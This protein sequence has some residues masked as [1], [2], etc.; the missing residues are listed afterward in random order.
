MK[1]MYKKITLIV[2]LWLWLWLWITTSF[3]AGT[4][5]SSLSNNLAFAPGLQATTQGYDLLSGKV[6]Q[7][8]PLVKGNI[9]F[10]M[11]YHASLRLEGEGG[12]NL[13]QELD[14]GGI[15]DWTNEYSGYVI[16]STAPSTNV[17]TFIIQLPRSSEKYI[18]T[19]D[20]GKFK[21]LYYNG[22][23]QFEAKTFYSDNLKDISFNQVN[24]AIVIVKDGVKFTASISKILES[25]FGASAIQAY[26]FKFTE[27]QYQD[28]RKLNLVYDN[29]YNLI[30]VKDNRNNILNILREYKKAG[31]TNQSYLERKLITGVELISG[32]NTQRSTITYQEAQVKSIIN[33]SKIETR[34]TVSAI[35]SV[36]V[37]TVIFQYE[38]QSRG[39]W[40][41]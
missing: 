30:Q 9:P 3:A 39:Y 33:P 27:I 40:I 32:S 13:Y 31:A 21:R 10:T 17:S 2:W 12:V 15:A 41:Q 16:T 14:E 8:V 1:D 35:N 20:G 28:G 19:K 24:G 5:Y 18:I 6:V 7:N 37:G 11:Q 25:N 23:G 22:A 34:Y 4:D 36:V 29:G 38:D 26:L